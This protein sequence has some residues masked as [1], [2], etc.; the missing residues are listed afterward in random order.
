[1]RA[2]PFLPEDEMPGNFLL[3][4]GTECST[5]TTS[6]SWPVILSLFFTGS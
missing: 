3:C 4:Q 5:E 2:F 6:I 1:M